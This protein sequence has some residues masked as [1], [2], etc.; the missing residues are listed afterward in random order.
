MHAH[1]EYYLKKN[2]GFPPHPHDLSFGLF[3]CISI[4]FIQHDK[5]TWLCSDM[6]NSLQPHGQ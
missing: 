5:K 3:T 2:S 1:R 6:S 4:K